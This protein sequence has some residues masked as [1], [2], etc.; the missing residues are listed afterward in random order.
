MY[1]TSD[2]RTLTTSNYSAIAIHA[3]YSS[4]FV[5]DEQMRALVEANPCQTV[6]GMAQQS[7]TLQMLS[8]QSETSWQ[9]GFAW[10]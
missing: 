5:D 6:Q 1:V 8:C 3:L 7:D 10:I 2:G 4:Q 9:A